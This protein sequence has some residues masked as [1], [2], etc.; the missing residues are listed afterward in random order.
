[1]KG[2]Y[3]GPIPVDTFFQAIW[4]DREF[5]RRHG[6]THLRGTFLYFTPCN[7]HG[8]PVS[9]RDEHGMPFAGYE[10]AGGYRS[11]ADLYDRCTLEPTLLPRHN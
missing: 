11:A 2:K 4:Q 9:V 5:F 6:I 10:T 3:G 8:E 1:M 7:A